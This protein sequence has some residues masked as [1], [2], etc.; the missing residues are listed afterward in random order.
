MDVFGFG[1]APRIAKLYKQQLYSFEKMETYR[2]K[3][4]SILPSGYIN[5]ELIEENWD[6]ILRLITSIKLKHCT[7]SQIFKRLNSYS[8][9]HPVYRAL[10]EY[11]KIIKTIYILRYINSLR[12]RQAIQQQLNIVELSNRLSSAITV[13]N[14]GEMIFLTHREQLIA[15]ACK[16]LIK[17]AITCWNYLFMTRHIQKLKTEKE[18]KEFIAALKE[19]TVIAWKHIYFNGLYD[20]SDEKLADSFNLLHSQNYDLGVV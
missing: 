8:R 17:S 1:F 14:G 4:Y 9:Q 6:A 5:V 7:A 10:K 19:G 20:F 2:S 13:A 16:N 3:G 18:K 15:D 11:G 12:L